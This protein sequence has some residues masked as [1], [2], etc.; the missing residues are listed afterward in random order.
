[1]GPVDSLDC[2]PALLHHR[3]AAQ[4]TYRNE[5]SELKHLIEQQGLLEQ[6]PLYYAC[7]IALNLGLL[8]L[9]VAVMAITDRLWL[10]LL[11]AVFLAFVF[12][13]IGF[14]GHDAA[15]WQI[16][17]GARKR[18]VLCLIH[19]NLLIGLSYGWWTD[20]HYRHHS[21]ANRLG[22]DP[23]I[24]Y[25]ATAFCEEH[26]RSKSGFWRFIVRH[27]AS[28]FLPL[29]ALVSIGMR[30]NSVKFLLR[31]RAKHHTVDS[32][33]LGAHFV[34]Y[35]SLVLYLLGGWRALLFVAVHQ[36]AAG[37]YMGSAMSVNHI[38]MPIVYADGQLDP[39][40]QQVLT[41]RNIRNHRLTD[42]LY[43]GLNFQI[44]HHLFPSMARNKM[45]EARG[46]IK[47][48]CERHSITY[49]ETNL[50]RSWREVLGHLRSVSS[51]LQEEGA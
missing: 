16:A 14:V 45:R 18:D 26:A 3:E 9:G 37:L 2:E 34:L 7:K 25:K 35:L 41:A 48:F 28:L 42:F 50:S 29:L 44:E 11:D 30:A 5:Y 23:D 46:T 22:V 19:L 33:M 47:L 32:L 31:G 17:R 20:K 38:G 24:S 1:M 51:S 6:Q 40:R 39:L 13:Q 12:G 43:G 10:Q 4:Y 27:Q 8:S 36:A 49:Y 21:D 15:H